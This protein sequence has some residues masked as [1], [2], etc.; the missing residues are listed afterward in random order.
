MTTATA[1]PENEQPD[2][3]PGPAAQCARCGHRIPHCPRCGIDDP[4][5]GGTVNGQYYCHT[6]STTKPTCYMITSKKAG[7]IR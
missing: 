4:F 1:Q 2:G 3:P 5:L 6:F 7:E